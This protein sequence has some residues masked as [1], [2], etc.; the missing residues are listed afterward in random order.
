MLCDGNPDC[1]DGEDEHSC[2]EFQCAGLLRCRD[3]GVCVHPTNICD[4]VVHC[5]ISRDDEKLCEILP[6]PGNCVCRGTVVKCTDLKNMNDLS[7]MTTAVVFTEI[8][9]SQKTSFGY[10]SHLLYLSITNCRFVNNVISNDV[11]TASPHMLTMVIRYSGVKFVRKNSFQ[12]MISLEIL[13]LFGNELYEIHSF[14]FN[15]LLSLVTLDLSKFKIVTVYAFAFS[16][17][18]KLKFLDLS[19]NLISTITSSAYYG[20]ISIQII[21]LRYNHLLFIEDL[22][23]FSMS[24]MNAVTVY[25]DTTLYCCS[26]HTQIGCFVDEHKVEPQN[27][28]PMVRV[29]MC[30][31]NI[32]C[33]L[34]AIF[35]VLGIFFYQKT[36]CRSSSH[37]KILINLLLANIIQSSYLC[38]RDALLLFNQGESIYLNTIWLESV[39]CCMLN[40]IFFVG[41]TNTKV[42]LFLLVLDQLIAV[43]YVL[44]RHLWSRNIFWCII[45]FW[46][47]TIVIAIVQQTF[48]A[49]HI[50]LCLPVLLTH[51]DTKRLVISYGLLFATAG[52]VAAIP[53]MYMAIARHVKASNISVH[54]KNTVANQKLIIRKG[55][56]ISAVGMFSWL[57]MFTAIQY[58]F[59]QQEETYTVN[60]IVDVAIHIFECVFMF[61]CCYIF[62]MLPHI[63]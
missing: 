11:F 59:I 7:V 10:F 52:I 39:T 6:C 23:L 29:R 3:D 48:I 27:C 2:E 56:A 46:T 34:S 63:S 22:K 1:P 16:G 45:C 58:S 62:K 47:V 26:L 49:N 37:F 13:D 19:T 33:S 54:S 21:D 50:A 60:N 20:I 28:G 43:K 4:G 55:V 18:T 42:F 44:K 31:F 14:S 51:S 35:I 25:L 15:G 38:I 40:V 41:F 12:S 8:L 17:M 5:L 9:F 32:V 61:Y 24:S 57:T 53:V 30:Y 36:T